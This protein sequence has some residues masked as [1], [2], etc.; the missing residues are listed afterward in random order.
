MKHN[1]K[2]ISKIV[3]ELINYL[4]SI[5]A[6]DININIQER[7]EE[8]KIIITSNYKEGKDNKINKLIKA[9][10]APKIEE[11]EEYY[12]ELA[13]ESDVGS[14]LHLIGMMVDKAE[15]SVIDQVLK[16]DISRNK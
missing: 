11:I 9:L 6:T 15:V 8:Y 16:L 3:D 4:F 14:E 12:W 13:G 7:S 1:K 5:G 10:N 2:R